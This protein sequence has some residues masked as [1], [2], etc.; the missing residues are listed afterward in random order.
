MFYYL[1]ILRCTD[2][3]LYIGTTHNL[4]ERIKWHNEGKGPNFTRIRLPVKLVYFEKFDNLKP[5]RRRK[6]QIKGWRREKKE[7]LIKY[8]YPKGKN[9]QT[10]NH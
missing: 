7:S 2:N 8:G 10:S 6:K 1:Y 3:K 4:P 5:A 9:Y